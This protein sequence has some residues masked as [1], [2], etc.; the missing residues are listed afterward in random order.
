MVETGNWREIQQLTEAHDLRLIER[1]PPKDENASI[2]GLIIL[3]VLLAAIMMICSA[4]VYHYK[5]KLNQLKDEKNE[6]K[7]LELKNFDP[8][9][10]PH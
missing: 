2:V 10:S 8:A 7:D 1:V 3:A 4:S 5:I 6:M 9:K